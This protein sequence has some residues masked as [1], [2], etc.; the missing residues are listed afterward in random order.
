MSSST[1]VPSCS[2]ARS[3]TSVRGEPFVGRDIKGLQGAPGQTKLGCGQASDAPPEL[4]TCYPSVLSSRPSPMEPAERETEE[5]WRDPEDA[6]P[7]SPIRGV[8]PKPR[9]V[10]CAVRITYKAKSRVLA[11]RTPPQV[12]P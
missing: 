9:M 4:S 5:E 6:S 2:T 12:G 10:R 3:R 11:R 7:A 1:A 8:L